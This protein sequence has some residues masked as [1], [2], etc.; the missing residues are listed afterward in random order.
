MALPLTFSAVCRTQG[1]EQASDE[2][3]ETVM[4]EVAAAQDV[5]EKGA[6][7]VVIITTVGQQGLFTTGTTYTISIT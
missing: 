2:N 5:L 7:L 1:G 6:P 3:R 4:F